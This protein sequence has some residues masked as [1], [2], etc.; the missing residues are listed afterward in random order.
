MS[1]TRYEQDI[2]AWAREQAA[3]L[4][5]GRVDLLDL[6][7]IA[8]EIEDVG[9][10]EQREL[11]S[12]MAVLLA[13]LFNWQYQPECRG[14]SW[15]VTIETQRE[16]IEATLQETPSLTGNLDKPEWAVKIWRQAKGIVARDLAPYPEL[17]DAFPPQCPWTMAQVLDP[18]WWPEAG[19]PIG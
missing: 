12:R 1:Q 6:E 17:I 16:D 4:R 14:S 3:L 8:D 9:K 18:A 19:A 2:V 10:S 13:R 11:V 7:H 15:R 5:A